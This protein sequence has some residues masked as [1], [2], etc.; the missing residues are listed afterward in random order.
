MA[1]VD[2]DVAIA[3]ETGKMVRELWE[4][5]GEPAYWLR[6]EPTTLSKRVG[7]DDHRPLLGE[8]PLD[9]LTS[10][11]RDRF[12]RYEEVSNFVVDTDDEDVKAIADRVLDAFDHRAQPG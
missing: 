5:G 9:L 10:M 7:H 2:V 11:A 6:T 3:E 4:Q 1:F 12:R 8:H